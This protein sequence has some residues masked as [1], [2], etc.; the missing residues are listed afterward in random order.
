MYDCR[1]KAANPPC[2]AAVCLL[3]VFLC[4]LRALCRTT[5]GVRY[6]SSVANPLKVKQNYQCNKLSNLLFCCRRTRVGKTPLCLLSL[7]SRNVFS[8]PF[9]FALLS[10]NAALCGIWNNTRLMRPQADSLRVDIKVAAGAACLQSEEEAPPLNFTSVAKCSSEGR[11]QTLH[12]SL[13]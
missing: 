10:V 8:L 9:C 5:A 3:C 4:I 12:C 6:F 7:C 2:L 11:S 13:A 1:D